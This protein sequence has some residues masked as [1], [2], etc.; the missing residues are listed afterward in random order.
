MS[1][2]AAADAA[3]VLPNELRHLPVSGEETSSPPAA[4]RAL[5][6]FLD[7]PSDSGLR[8]FALTR[9]GHSAQTALQPLK[10]VELARVAA[11]LRTRVVRWLPDYGCAVLRSEPLGD[12]DDDAAMPVRL[13]VLGL[14]GWQHRVHSSFS[15]ESFPTKREHCAEPSSASP[16]SVG[17][18]PP[19]ATLDMWLAQFLA[20]LTKAQQQHDKQR[21]ASNGGRGHQKTPGFV[22]ALAQD[23]IQALETEQPPTESPP[24]AGFTDVGRHTGGPPRAT[25]WALVRAAAQYALDEVCGPDTGAA[26]ARCAQLL[27]DV[28]AWVLG[29]HVAELEAAESQRRG[30]GVERVSDVDT[31]QALL[32]RLLAE[33]ESLAEQGYVVEGLGEWCAGVRRRVDVL[34]RSYRVAED[35]MFVLPPTVDLA[36]VAKSPE[37]HTRPPEVPIPAEPAEAAAA[38]GVTDCAAAA[39]A[40]GNVRPFDAPLPTFAGVCEWSNGVPGSA[41]L[42]LRAIEQTFWK[43]CTAFFGSGDSAGTMPATEVESIVAAVQ[44]YRSVLEEYMTKPPQQLSDDAIAVGVP[45]LRSKEM[46]VVWA[47]ACLTHRICATN[48]YSEVYEYRLPI[49]HESMGHLVL[50]ERAEIDA[51]KAVASYIFRFSGRS[52]TLW[53]ESSSTSMSEFAN[54]IASKDRTMATTRDR[55][56]AIDAKLKADHW[57]EIQQRK[58]LLVVLRSRLSDARAKL[59]D[60]EANYRRTDWSLISCQ[61]RVNQLLSEIEE[62]NKAPPTAIL[63]LPTADRDANFVLF[64][65]VGPAVLTRLGMLLWLAQDMLLPRVPMTMSTSTFSMSPFEVKVGKSW[66]EH[67]SI[68]LDLPAQVPGVDLSWGPDDKEPQSPSPSTVDSYYWD[69]QGVWNPNVQKILTWR[70]SGTK[71]HDPFKGTPAERFT[72]LFY[73]PELPGCPSELQWVALVTAAGD[74]SRNMDRANRWIAHQSR[75]RTHLDW[76]GAPKALQDFS[77]L[78]AGPLQQMRRICCLLLDPSACLSQPAMRALVSHALHNIGPIERSDGSMA[79]AWHQDAERGDLIRVMCRNLSDFISRSCHLVRESRSALVVA[80][81]CAFVC[82]LDTTGEAAA[83]AR[84]AA[85]MCLGWASAVETDRRRLESEKKVNTSAVR[86]LRA[87]EGLFYAYALLC[88]RKVAPMSNDE[89]GMVLLCL[90]R[91]HASRVFAQSSTLLGELQAVEAQCLDQV[92]GVIKEY[93]A[94]VSGEKLTA[95]LRSVYC[96]IGDDVE[97]K[98]FVYGTASA[99]EHPTSGVIYSI[100]ILTGEVLIDGYP[101]H[102]L[103]AGVL[104]SALY[105]RSFGSRDFEAVREGNSWKTPHPQGGF[106]YEFALGSG[107][108]VCI[109]ETDADTGTVLELLDSPEGANWVAEI[110]VLFRNTCSFWA[111]RDKEAIVA[112]PVH[113]QSHEASLLFVQRGDRR[114][115]CVVPK[116]KRTEPLLSLLSMARGGD[117]PEL[118]LPAHEDDALARLLALLC[119]FEEADVI[120]L[121]LSPAAGEGARA[122]RFD[123]PRF[124]LGFELC[125]DG[126]VASLDRGN[127]RLA[128]CQQMSR[129]LPRFHDYLVLEPRSDGEHVELFVADGDVIRDHRSGFTAVKRDHLRPQDTRRHFSL[130]VSKRLHEL[131]GCTALSR[132][133]LAAILAAGG[134]MLGDTSERVPGAFAAQTLVQQSFQWSPLSGRERAKL[135]EVFS[136]AAGF[137]A[138]A[139]QCALLSR[140]TSALADLHKDKGKCDSENE[141]PLPLEDCES[142]YSIASQRGRLPA[143]AA[144][145]AAEE[146]RL[147]GIAVARR[148]C[149]AHA[150]AKTES[151]LPLRMADKVIGSTEQSIAS[152]ISMEDN[153]EL[154][155]AQSVFPL[156]HL[157]DAGGQSH[158]DIFRLMLRELED[159]WKLHTAA[160]VPVFR[161]PREEVQ[162]E[163][164]RLH[165]DADAFSSLLYD[166]LCRLYS[167]QFKP[168]TGSASAYADLAHRKNSLVLSHAANYCPLLTRSAILRSLADSPDA[169]LPLLS[170]QARED[171]VTGA[172]SLAQLWVL[173]DKLKRLAAFVADPEQLVTRYY[174]EFMPRAWGVREHP[175]WLAF[176]ASSGIQVRPEQSALALHLIAHPGDI[177]QLNMGLGKT[178]VV[179]PLLLLHYTQRRD[180]PVVRVTFCTQLLRECV[181]YLQ[182]YL[183]AG[184]FHIPALLLPFNR[185]TPSTPLLLRS[186]CLA[187]KRCRDLGGFMALA[188]EHRLSLALKSR[189][190]SNG[191]ADGAGTA[192]LFERCLAVRTVDI[193]D[194]SD[195]VLHP[196]YELVYALGDPA[197][198]ESG[199]SR[200]ACVEAVLWALNSPSDEL[201]RLL[202]L[203]GVTWAVPQWAAG[204]FREFRFLRGAAYE[205]A[206]AGIKRQVALQLC[207]SPPHELRWLRGL[208]EAPRE[209]FVR[210]VTDSAIDVEEAQL[211]D[212][213]GA[214]E[215]RKEH[216]LVL[217]GLLAH[218]VVFSALEKRHRVDYG[219]DRSRVPRRSL[220]VPFRGSDSPA[221]RAEFN[222]ADSVIVLTCLSAYYNGLEWAQLRHAIEVLLGLPSAAAQDHYALWLRT[223]DDGA[224]KPD[225]RQSI[226]A[227]DRLDVTSELQRDVLTRAFA[228]SPAAIDFWLNVAVFPVEMSQFAKRLKQSAWH[229]APPRTVGFSGTNDINR[230]MPLTLRPVPCIDGDTTIAATNGRMLDVI[231]RSSEV[232]LLGDAAKQRVCE[233]LLDCAADQSRSCDVCAL[234]DAGALL[235]GMSNRA[236]ASCLL[237]K[238][239]PERL[240]GVVYYE[241]AQGSGCWVVLERSGRCLPLGSSPVHER[242]TFVLFDEPHSRG[243]DM[244]LRPRARAL[245]TLGTQMCK[246]KFMQGAGRMRALGHGQ[247]L[248]I[249]VVPE[250]QGSIRASMRSADAQTREISV[251]DVLAWVFCNTVQTVQLLLPHWAE[252]GSHYVS[253]VANGGAPVEP[254]GMSLRDLYAKGRRQQV[255]TDLAN[256]YSVSDAEG[257]TA[258]SLKMSKRLLDCCA[259]YQKRSS[260]TGAQ[261]SLE[262]ECERELEH[263]REMEEEKEEE[264]PEKAPRDESFWDPL[265]I[266]AARDIG[267]VAQVVGARP[268]S[269]VVER[270]FSQ[271]SLLSSAVHWDSA[272]V[273]ATDNFVYAVE[274][275][276]HY[277]RYLR[278][279]DA[280]LLAPAEPRSSRIAV[281]LMSELEA[282]RVLGALQRMTPQQA[283]S[284]SLAF[285]NWSLLRYGDAH[286]PLAFTGFGREPMATQLCEPELAALQ[287]FLGEATLSRT[288]GEDHEKVREKR[289][290]AVARLLKRACGSEKCVRALLQMRRAASQYDRSDIQSAVEYIPV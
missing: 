11:W 50:H 187:L 195:A 222:H 221:P 102:S 34:Q 28:Y 39:Q 4:L 112:R 191:A 71:I 64:F 20:L 188:P 143:G 74:S 240:R 184:L 52:G 211:E 257:N 170:Q 27:V 283:Q 199:E 284:C 150:V 109:R 132:L 289:V 260:C 13:T 3:L 250:I 5:L 158:E 127:Y 203:P 84:S 133:H 19:V 186:Y 169:L 213:A 107:G 190:A 44:R 65:L 94:H 183:T 6:D 219:V 25:G 224:T 179:L 126:S 248:K 149:L 159:S 33:S 30:S 82:Q 139:A 194:E 163:L 288:E 97:L 118:V 48:G 124:G 180:G 16:V 247:T 198:L 223:I 230:V 111:C 47:A 56:R 267:A 168:E 1:T 141:S 15:R 233:Q 286:T 178:R 87:K 95:A 113:F 175:R 88:C 148:P 280:C 270:C 262:E 53:S 135:R 189:E 38:R 2:N 157:G 171:F 185:G 215:Q 202:S 46:L 276:V 264:I 210:L 8:R 70:T 17:E 140:E 145:T 256:K 253:S 18:L 134:T 160:K 234:I 7:E 226:S 114:V 106:L 130:E 68:H 103:P 272:C 287:V 54:S 115:C 182:Q 259:E 117:L 9:P 174:T 216:V 51:A 220:A 205:R 80:V 12:A 60:E 277:D 192:A 243:S 165:V 275:T 249:V 235:A 93:G 22:A 166:E 231:R 121:V 110:P 173:C 138:L 45:Y 258:A 105:Q 282:D 120:H 91:F 101:L 172:F 119:K 128:E 229:L 78:R 154:K 271:S 237:A 62:A 79:L 83:V 122:L 100:N 242:D 90:V 123:L 269:V 181:G 278:F 73:T 57:D 236:A 238:G 37:A 161:M 251:T 98:W 69:S 218:E 274:G 61:R 40:V 151:A 10:P 227:T 246:D 96:G 104:Q 89:A 177:A 200:W 146:N 144:L 35:A 66:R 204:S 225:E 36:G 41:S 58:S 29:R 108:A 266:L 176:E 214:N 21:S 14:D 244:K 285:A 263:E 232:L 197:G 265:R 77:C 155:G 129:L 24:K 32:A 217:R 81:L 42:K 26:G 67:V 59:R 212:V 209:Q 55:L 125:A 31:A 156:A 147:L 116:E 43:H 23:A 136:F 99:A 164:T 63:N 273:W 152:L 193:V 201:R 92:S 254:D 261:H 137:P 245:I 196:K 228:R 268:L 49:R 255:L 279:P 239:L 162:A 208:G 241:A 290:Q 86:E 252:N 131:Q 153:A 142:E 76:L 75:L 206:K 72:E 207:R 281:L 167:S 85:A